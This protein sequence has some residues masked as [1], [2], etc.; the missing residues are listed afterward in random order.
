MN[1]SR[2]TVS[3]YCATSIS[4]HDARHTTISNDECG[5]LIEHV[6]NLQELVETVCA[7]RLDQ[8]PDFEPLQQTGRRSPRAVECQHAS[9][10][11]ARTAGRREAGRHPSVSGLCRRG[12][13][14]R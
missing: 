13:A 7:V 12:M 6:D 11:V 14:G 9:P 4:R 3:N 1:A 5:W 8:K 2:R 10:S